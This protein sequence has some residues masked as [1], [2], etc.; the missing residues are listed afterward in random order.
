MSNRATSF[1][2]SRSRAQP[3]FACVFNIIIF[4]F[5]SYFRYRISE[6]FIKQTFS[7]LTDVRAPGSY[8]KNHFESTH[9]KKQIH[10]IYQSLCE[11]H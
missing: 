10:H 7:R 4:V 9:K 8:L 3:C 1:S 6:K 2:V 11:P 5:I